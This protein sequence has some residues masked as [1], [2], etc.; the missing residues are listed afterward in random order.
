MFV[1]LINKSESEIRDFDPSRFLFDPVHRCY[2]ISIYT[3]TLRVCV[4][5][6]ESLHYARSWFDFLLDSV[7]RGGC[8][9]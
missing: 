6:D 8:E 2:I 7:Q 9:D 1:C 3:Y 4:K 5:R